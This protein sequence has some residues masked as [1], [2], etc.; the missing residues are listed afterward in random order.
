MD[1]S[2]RSTSAPGPSPSDHQVGNEREGAHY[3]AGTGDHRSD[4][5]IEVHTLFLAV[6]RHDEW[7]EHVH[8]LPSNLDG[9]SGSTQVVA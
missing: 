3:R 4:A 2:R 9:G 6:I 7:Q 1:Q 8:S 5:R